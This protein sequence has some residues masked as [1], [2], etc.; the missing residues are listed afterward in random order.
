MVG[1]QMRCV[2]MAAVLD[3]PITRAASLRGVD[4]T[5][6]WRSEGARNGESWPPMPMILPEITAED[7]NTGPPKD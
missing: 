7:R 2:S 3:L 4:E 5:G 1:T 6:E